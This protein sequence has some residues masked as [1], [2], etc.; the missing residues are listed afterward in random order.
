MV[1][2]V[3]AGYLLSS[4]GEGSVLKSSGIH[5]KTTVVGLEFGPP[6]SSCDLE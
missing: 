5:P 4:L 6:L 3:I 1:G 2:P